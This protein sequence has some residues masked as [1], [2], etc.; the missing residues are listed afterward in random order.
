MF[1]A[2]VEVWRKWNLRFGKVWKKYGTFFSVVA[3]GV[4]SHSYAINIKKKDP[5][6]N[7][8]EKSDIGIYAQIYFGVSIF[9]LQGV[10]S[11]LGVGILPALDHKKW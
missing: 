1:V 7:A 9:S 4:W 6:L 10:L 8:A 3:A 5:H 2:T 11:V